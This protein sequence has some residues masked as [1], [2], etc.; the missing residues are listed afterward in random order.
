M[1]ALSIRMPW[2]WL[3][4]R[5]DITDPVERVRQHGHAI[6]DIE[7][8][9]WKTN[10]RGRVAI[11]AGRTYALSEHERIAED[12]S[13]DLLVQLP[14]YD[15]L[16]AGCGNLLGEVIVTDCVSEH[17]SGW[18]SGPYGLVLANPTPYRH[19]VPYKGMLGFFEVPDSDVAGVR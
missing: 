12:L 17:L 11:H 6:K 3:I 16:V 5:P 14:P 2:A 13:N 18:F 9:T 10:F 7:N 1:K 8:R 19:P 15:D 4:L